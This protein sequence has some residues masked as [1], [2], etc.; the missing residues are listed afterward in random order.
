M[1]KAHKSNLMNATR[2]KVRPG[3]GARAAATLARRLKSR[4][5]LICRCRYRCRC[6]Y[7]CRYSCIRLAT[8]HKFRLLI[9]NWDT[10]C[11]S[12]KQLLVRPT[13]F[14]VFG[15]VLTSICFANT[16]ITTTLPTTATT[17]TAVRAPAC[18][19]CLRSR[20]GLALT[21]TPCTVKCNA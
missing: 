16:C 18:C 11:G 12:C 4:C 7:I 15:K 6:R 5:L 8:C 21:P 1:D 9:P 17:T 20:L 10:V 13:K 19:S 14:E 3:G 2:G